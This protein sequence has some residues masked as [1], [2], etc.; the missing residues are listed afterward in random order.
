[1]KGTNDA[2]CTLTSI[3]ILV[4]VNGGGFATVTNG[5][6]AS[7]PTITRTD[8]LPL[9]PAQETAVRNLIRGQAELFNLMAALSWPGALLLPP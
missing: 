7:M 4:T 3:D 5:P 2:Y 6:S 8:S 1:L 9:T